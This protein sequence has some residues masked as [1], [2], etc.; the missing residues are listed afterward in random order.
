MDRR[1]RPLVVFAIAGAVAIALLVMVGGADHHSGSVARAAAP[2][3]GKVTVGASVRGAGRRVKGAFRGAPFGH[4]R[5]TLTLH[6]R[7][8]AR[9]VTARW[10]LSV[11][12]GSLRGTM[13]L[14]TRG[15]RISGTFA[16][17]TGRG[18]LRG[19][20]GTGKVTGTWARSG[21]SGARLRVRL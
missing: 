2:P 8:P 14:R 16:A 11:A 4:G 6:S 20:T 21:R 7:L 3:S 5:L 19:L 9:R 18:S 12:K 10:V 17:T 15:R 13:R 1:A